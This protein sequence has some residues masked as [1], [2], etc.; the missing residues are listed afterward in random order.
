M[1][2]W[3]GGDGGGV[4]LDGGVFFGW[5]TVCLDPDLIFGR[6]G[7]SGPHLGARWAAGGAQIFVSRL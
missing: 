4:L 2:S 1:A 3:T 7:I 5:A 6:R